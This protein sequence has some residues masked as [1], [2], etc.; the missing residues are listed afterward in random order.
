MSASSEVA[1]TTD[2][3]IQEYPPRE[4]SGFVDYRMGKISVSWRGGEHYLCGTC[5]WPDNYANPDK[6]G[7]AH[8]A[9]IIKFR[10]EHAA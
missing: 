9:R 6:K 2:I 7:C 1:A 4:V 8:I 10:A 5:P 3:A